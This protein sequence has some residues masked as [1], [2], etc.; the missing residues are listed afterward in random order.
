MQRVPWFP[1]PLRRW[2][3]LYRPQPGKVLGC[4][5]LIDTPPLRAS[6]G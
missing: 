5:A 2:R 4:G 1:S 6:K 3:Y